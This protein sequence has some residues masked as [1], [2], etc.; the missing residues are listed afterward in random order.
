MLNKED[1]VMEKKIRKTNGVEI[2]HR[3]Y[4]GEDAERKA[5]LQEERVN[6]EVAQTIYELRKDAG[7]TQKAL[8]DLV[9][10]TQSVIS[11]LEDA[12]YEGHS[13]SMLNR[14]AKS[15]NRRVAIHLKAD[16]SKRGTIRYVFRE[17]L[18]G[19][20]RKQGLTP[21]ELAAKLDL[22]RDEIIAMERQDD[23][24]PTPLTLFKLSKFYRV[25]QRNLAILAGAIT[26]VPREF[27]QEVSKFAAKSE[28]FSK[29]S[30]GEQQILD[31][32]VKFLKTLGKDD[33]GP[34]DTSRDR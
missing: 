10:T 11:R 28:S 32:F 29:L 26:D 17:V 5:S 13:L 9:G 1:I 18:R 31:E 14:I 33:N 8:A 30:Q 23:Y 3:R 24:R 12:D 19:L 25:S 2:L 21:E 4:V 22:L 15:L 27:Q 6:A 20:R 34:E 16:D 7:L